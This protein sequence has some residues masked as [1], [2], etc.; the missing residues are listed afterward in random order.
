MIGSSSVVA[1]VRI[2]DILSANKPAVLYLSFKTAWYGDEDRQRS[3]GVPRSCADSRLRRNE[4]RW[5]F[6]CSISIIRYTSEL[7]WA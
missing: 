6:R 4:N 2:S 3:R 7:I 5:R 1:E